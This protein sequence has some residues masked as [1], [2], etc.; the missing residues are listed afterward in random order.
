M[1]LVKLYDTKLILS[2]PLCFCAVKMNYQKNK[3][4]VLFTIA[5]KSKIPRN[6]F[7]QGSKRPVH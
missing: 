3:K 7:N 4:T 5:S 2:N 1:N 6:K